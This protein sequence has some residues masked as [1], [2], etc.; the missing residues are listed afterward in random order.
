M[1]TLS[2]QKQKETTMSKAET[3]NVKECK[4]RY[5]TVT[6]CACGRAPA[7][8]EHEYVCGQTDGGVT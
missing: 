3:T 7:N 1:M 6:L 5:I 4:E 8:G 2:K